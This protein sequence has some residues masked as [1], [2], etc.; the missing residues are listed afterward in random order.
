M[1]DDCNWQLAD[2]EEGLALNLRS[3][4]EKQRTDKT[5]GNDETRKPKK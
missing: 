3:L 2:V 4:N 5:G 1:D